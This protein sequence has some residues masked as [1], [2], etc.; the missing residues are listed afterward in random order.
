MDDI[1]L[2]KK[3]IFF[4]GTRRGLKEIDLIFGRFLAAEIDRLTVAEL[5]ELRDLLT[6]PD[7]DLLSWFVDG[8]LP[9]DRQTPLTARIRAAAGTAV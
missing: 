4:R 8:Q 7:N 3:E 1:T 5:H 2:L 6:V 9:A